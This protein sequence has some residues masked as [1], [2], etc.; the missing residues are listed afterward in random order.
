MVIDMVIVEF[1]EKRCKACGLCAD[2][3]P[4]GIIYVNTD[5]VMVN[6]RGCAELKENKCIGCKSCVTVCPDAAISLR[7]TDE[8]K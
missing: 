2:A 4:L 7:R 1:N 3:C 8:D 6:G 5:R